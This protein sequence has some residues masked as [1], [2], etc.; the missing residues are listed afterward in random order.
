MRRKSDLPFGSEFSP[1]QIDL[2]HVLD[3]AARHGG[4]WRT[5]E[6]A[7]CSAYF[8]AHSTSDYN[9]GK[10]ANNTSLGMIAYD[11]IDRNVLTI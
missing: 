2:A 1:S 10:L 9:R 6:N 5:F 8:E 7:V 3:L 11:I 4:D